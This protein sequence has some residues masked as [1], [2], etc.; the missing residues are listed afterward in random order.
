MS[1]TSWSVMVSL[2]I[3]LSTM[4]RPMTS[5]PAMKGTSAKVFISASDATSKEG[6]SLKDRDCASRTLKAFFPCVMTCGVPHALFTLSSW[7]TDSPSRDR[8]TMLSSS[9]YWTLCAGC[10]KSVTVKLFSVASNYISWNTS[11]TDLSFNNV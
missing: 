4:I 6:R 7:L 2:V 10:A 9:C 8:R 11:A 3:A 5:V 1:S